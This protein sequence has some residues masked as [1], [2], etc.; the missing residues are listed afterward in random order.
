MSYHQIKA[1]M[2]ARM[3][4]MTMRRMMARVPAADLAGTNPTHFAVALKYDD[5]KTGAPRVV[6]KAADLLA[7]TIRDLAKKSRTRRRRR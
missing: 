6:A 3:R 7:T 2:R 4:E 1:D 5:K